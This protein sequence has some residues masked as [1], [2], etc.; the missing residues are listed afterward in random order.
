VTSSD[1][2]VVN[3]LLCCNVNDLFQKIQQLKERVLCIIGD[4]GG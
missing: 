1:G 4:S 2:P 3:S